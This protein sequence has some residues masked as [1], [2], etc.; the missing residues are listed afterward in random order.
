MTA[1]SYFR[2]MPLTL[3]HRNRIHCIDVHH[4]QEATTA[5]ES[6]KKNL[7]ADA[8]IKLASSS[9]SSSREQECFRPRTVWLDENKS[10]LWTLKRATPIQEDDDEI[11]ESPTKK[12]KR[13]VQLHWEHVVEDASNHECRE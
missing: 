2:N 4:Q 8:Q 5:A 12:T 10:E 6:L 9:S 13:V 3:R 1:V 7:P 11:V